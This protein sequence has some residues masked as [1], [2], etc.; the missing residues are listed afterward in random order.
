MLIENPLNASQLAFPALECSHIF[1]FAF[2]VG[3]VA[4]VNFRLIGIGMTNQSP[5]RLWKDTFWSTLAGLIVVVFSGLLLL[6][7]SRPR[8]SK[9]IATIALALWACVAF[10]GIFIG[11]VY[12]TLDY[13]Y[14]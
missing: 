5:A 6:A 1:G 11:F 13:K 9:T 10:G 14:I 7:S 12:S 2:S 4:I 3:T 8:D